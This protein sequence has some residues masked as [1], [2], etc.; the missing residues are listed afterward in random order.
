MNGKWP[1][2]LMTWIDKHVFKHRSQRFCTACA[3]A[4]YRKGLGW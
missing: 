3:R 4:Y 1:Y 2:R